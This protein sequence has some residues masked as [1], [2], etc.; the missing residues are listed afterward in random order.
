M[1]R[2][3]SADPYADWMLDGGGWDGAAEA[4]CTFC[5]DEVALAWRETVRDLLDRLDAHECPPKGS[6]Q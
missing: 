5:R 3:S 2:P 4:T 6:P 1:T